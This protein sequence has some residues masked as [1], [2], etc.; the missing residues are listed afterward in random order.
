[1]K[2]FSALEESLLQGLR[3]RASDIAS[4]LTR[5]VV[6]EARLRDLRGEILQSD[7]M[8]AHFESNR[9]DLDALRHDKP[10]ASQQL[11]PRRRALPSYVRQR[12]KG[13]GGVV[14]VL[15]VGNASYHRP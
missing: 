7:R 13:R 12:V 8:V 9:D 5:T 2:L 15:H 3:Y 6:Q 14:S 11:A 1:M 10:L 4:S